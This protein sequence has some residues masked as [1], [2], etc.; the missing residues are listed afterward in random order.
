MHY[1]R[2]PEDKYIY[3]E[4]FVDK[5]GKLTYVVNNNHLENNLFIH[6]QVIPISRY[7]PSCFHGLILRYYYDEE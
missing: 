4:C 2:L 1:H 7:V 6:S 3:Y 5:K